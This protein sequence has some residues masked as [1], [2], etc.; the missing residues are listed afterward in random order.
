MIRILH[1]SLYGLCALLPVA[2][3]TGA[4]WKLV[5]SSEVDGEPKLIKKIV[6]KGSGRKVT[7]YLCAFST[8]DYT[9]KVVD[10]G[11]SQ[12]SPRYRNLREAMEKNGCTA[13]VNGGFFGTDF[14][15]LGAV[16]ADGEKIT[17]YFN[18]NR[19]GL[20]SGVIWS[21]T[22]GIHI[23]RR[24]DFKAGPGVKQAIQTGPMLISQSTTVSGLSNESWRPRTFV[25]TDWKGNWMLGTSSS[26]SLAALAD[27]LD[28]SS[29]FPEMVVNRAIN[30]D[31]GRSTGLYLKQD[32]GKVTYRSEISTVRNFLGIVPK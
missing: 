25:L 15:A 2:H 23:V 12:S 7:L 28:S 32:T 31:G 27:I 30:L 14:K 21:G 20:A 29:A 1:L 13:G 26:V 3:V 24:H 17:S 22:G 10:Q 8:N 11:S 4:E 6:S 5:E 19:S 16:Y 18:S 9:L